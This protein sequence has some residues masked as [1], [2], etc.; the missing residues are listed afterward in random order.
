MEVAKSIAKAAIIFGAVGALLALSA[1]IIGG[2]LGEAAL[3][4]TAYN[5]AMA[6]PKN[7]VW[8]AAFFGTFGAIHAALIPVFDGLFGDKKPEVAETQKE[9][10]GRAP[11]LTIELAPDQEKELTQALSKFQ[12]RVKAGKVADESCGKS[13]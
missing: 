2:V 1:P 4:T 7:V 10:S 13:I 8:E 9:K 11:T 5:I 3:G 6:M 12:D